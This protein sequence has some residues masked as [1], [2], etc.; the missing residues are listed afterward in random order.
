MKNIEEI[1][2]KSFSSRQACIV[3]GWRFKEIDQLSADEVYI[4]LVSEDG[5]EYKGIITG[6]MD[7]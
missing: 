1:K 4:H 6:V 3:G 5:Y 7:E 2:M